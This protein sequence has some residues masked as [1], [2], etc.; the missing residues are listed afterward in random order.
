M[1]NA[2]QAIKLL[3]EMKAMGIHL[4]VDDF[5]AGY[6]SLAYLRNLPVDCVKVDRAFI[7]DIPDKIDDMAISK[8]I[9]MLGQSLRL[10]VIAEGIET[11]EQFDFLME[12][13]CDEIQGYLFSKPLAAVKVVSFLECGCAKDRVLVFDL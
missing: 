12:H 3:R 5:G 8:T 11:Q 9:I 10:K 4:S 7:K 13:G 1:E 2:E 6:S